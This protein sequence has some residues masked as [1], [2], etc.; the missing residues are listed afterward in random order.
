MPSSDKWLHTTYSCLPMKAFFNQSLTG[1]KR[2]LSNFVYNLYN[3]G[4]LDFEAF[5]LDWLSLTRSEQLRPEAASIYN[6]CAMLY[7]FIEIHL[8]IWIINCH[9]FMSRKTGWYLIEDWHFSTSLQTYTIKMCHKN[10]KSR[11]QRRLYQ[12]TTQHIF[13]C[14]RRS[15]I[16]FTIEAREPVLNDF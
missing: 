11:R 8:Y 16:V 9:Y 14:F 13:Q 4:S 1:F 5:V 15:N 6:N 10:N 3:P 7:R 12:A 2:Y